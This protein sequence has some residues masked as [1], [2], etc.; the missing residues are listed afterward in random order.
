[1][2]GLTI[3]LLWACLFAAE[4]LTEGVLSTTFLLAT[5]AVAGYG[6]WCFAGWMLE[7]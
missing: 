3:L 6:G 4:L 2:R 5:W 1:V 7:K